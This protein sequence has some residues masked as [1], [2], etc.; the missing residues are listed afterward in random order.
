M[1]EKDLLHGEIERVTTRQLG[2]VTRAQ[3]ID[4]GWPP[5]TITHQIA[6][7]VLIPG[8]AGVYAG[9]HVPRHAHPR[10]SAAVLACGDGAALSHAAA[11]ALWGVVDWPASLEVSA[12]SY[13]RR[14]G[15]RTHRSRNLRGDIRRH[16]GIPVTTPARTVLDLQPRLTDAR[17]VRLVNDLR[18]ARHLNATAFQRLCTRSRRVDSLLGDSERPTRS[19]PEDLLKPF[20]RRHDLPFPE[21]NVTLE[22]GREVDAF[23]RAEKLIIEIDSWGFHGHRVAFRR[24]R[25]KDGHAHAPRQRAQR[26]VPHQMDDET[27]DILRR[28]LAQYRP[29]PRA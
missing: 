17:L 9:G 15:I 2:H 7:G 4:A 11:A 8:H 18:V 5:R 14:R 25:R 22:G 28:T 12:P 1:L 19:L 16:H 6:R 10:S 13:H 3:L 20:L 26:Q 29:S 21:F 23:Y 27:A 24:D